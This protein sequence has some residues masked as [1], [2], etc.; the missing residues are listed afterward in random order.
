LKNCRDDLHIETLHPRP[1]KHL[2]PG[3]FVG[4]NKKSP[5][6]FPGAV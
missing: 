4:R 1:R 6:I 2:T 5:Q 3:E